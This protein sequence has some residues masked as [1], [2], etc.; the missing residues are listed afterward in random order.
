[1]SPKT[2]PEA[3]VKAN[4]PRL[5]TNI[6]A[7]KYTIMLDVWRLLDARST[8]LRADRQK[9]TVWFVSLYPYFVTFWGTLVESEVKTFVK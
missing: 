4:R 8:I 2:D 6:S 7:V 9:I 5:K 1:L 3:K